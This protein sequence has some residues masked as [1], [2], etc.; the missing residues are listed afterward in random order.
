MKRAFTSSRVHPRI[1]VHAV[2][3]STTLQIQSRIPLL[4]YPFN[5]CILLLVAFC[6]ATT[7][8]ETTAAEAIERN[9]FFRTTR[10]SI[11]NRPSK[12]LG[13]QIGPLVLST[14]AFLRPSPRTYSQN[15]ISNVR[16]PFPHPFC[17]SIVIATND[18]T[19]LRVITFFGT[20]MNL[21]RLRYPLS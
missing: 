20:T 13:F 10:E 18:Y 14:N 19:S 7:V 8:V 21:Y 5:G 9:P 2:R 11:G 4:D 1:E 17:S 6:G 16:H 15:P 3:K 12:R